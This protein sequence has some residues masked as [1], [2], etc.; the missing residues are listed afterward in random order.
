MIA[1]LQKFASPL[2]GAAFCG[3]LCSAEHAEHA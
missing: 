3:G 1:V 2:V